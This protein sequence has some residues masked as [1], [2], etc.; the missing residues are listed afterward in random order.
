[1]RAVRPVTAGWIVV[2]SLVAIW[3]S[4]A[5]WDW[6]ATPVVIAALFAMGSVAKWI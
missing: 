6:W 5:W 3:F 1:M 4:I 2:I